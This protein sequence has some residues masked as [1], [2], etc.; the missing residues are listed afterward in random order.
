MIVMKMMSTMT[1]ILML[2]MMMPTS[3][4][5]AMMATTIEKR[6]SIEMNSRIKKSIIH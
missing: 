3:M 2:T 5:L 4:M 1:M 6:L